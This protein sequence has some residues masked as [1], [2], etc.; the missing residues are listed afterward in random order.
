MPSFEGNN[1]KED[2][3]NIYLQKLQRTLTNAKI[4]LALNV[5]CNYFNFTTLTFLLLI[6]TLTQCTHQ[7][8]GVNF[9]SDFACARAF[10]RAGGAD[11][12]QA[13]IFCIRPSISPAQGNDTVSRCCWTRQK[14]RI[15]KHSLGDIY[16]S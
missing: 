4:S 6:Y 10:R 15:R 8:H 16:Q 9:M 5:Q 13:G 12:V 3:S 1:G 14:H 7:S 2:Y 11:M